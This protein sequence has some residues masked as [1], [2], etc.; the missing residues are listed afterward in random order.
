M[1][2][3][4]AAPVPTAVAATTALLLLLLALLAASGSAAGHPP[5]S[6]DHGVDEGAFDTLWSRDTARPADR[7]DSLT[8]F[9]AKT[10]DHTFP[11]PPE[12]PERWTRGEHQEIAGAFDSNADRDTQ[13]YTVHPGDEPLRQGDWIKDAYADVFAIA[14][15]TVVHA[16]DART[17]HVVPTSG[18]VLGVVDFR[19]EF[20]SSTCDWEIL[21]YKLESSRL[22]NPQSG[23]V[24]ASRAGTSQIPELQYSDLSPDV[25]LLEFEA[26]IS[27]R[28]RKP[29]PPGC[30]GP[31]IS[32]QKRLTVSDTVEVDPTGFQS[33]GT[34]A[35][36]PGGDAGIFVYNQ[37]LWRGLALPNG[38]TV[39]SPFRFFSA[40]RP[41]WDGTSV[42]STGAS[43]P[44]GNVHAHPLQVHAYP[45]RRG[46]RVTGPGTGSTEVTDV[47]G[48]GTVAPDLP[49][50]VAVDVP[51]RNYT[52]PYGYGVRYPGET[53]GEVVALPL[54]AGDGE[55]VQPPPGREPK[56]IRRS[57]I[58]VETVRA[59]ASNA[60][61][62]VTLSD[63]ETGDP[64]STEITDGY[65]LIQGERRINMS[66]DGESVLTIPRPTG[67][68]SARYVPAPWYTASE[69]YEGDAAVHLV[70][71][72]EDAPSL[73]DTL[74][75]FMAFITPFLVMI[76]M[77]D[78]AFSLD[79]W[80]PWR[81][82]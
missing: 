30:R 18:S 39:R 58:D 69:P 15:S 27:V 14:P 55:S 7:N 16:S 25:R 78:R 54:Y 75:R 59:N 48:I 81:E 20:P 70:T 71:Q 9:I 35:S 42:I 82:L 4:G 64:I 65:V 47:V 31:G 62:R 43:G 24:I 1:S 6:T 67:G 45:S 76:Y 10:S 2:G 8:E 34:F 41:A 38:A 40:R 46:V 26:T 13:T 61:I 17:E 49:P 22:K 52:L 57:D 29:A 3:R 37:E 19:I 36:Y 23:D 50:E 53:G 73:P 12:A 21:D 44:S 56:E 72:R 51:Q 68:V 79:V 80:P 63:R 32:R 11:D 28:A 74:V 66:N 5:S 60:T 77:L 33:L